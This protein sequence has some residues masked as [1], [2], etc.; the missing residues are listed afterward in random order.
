MK[1]RQP[2]FTPKVG[3]PALYSDEWGA[4]R[5]KVT[6]VSRHPNSRGYYLC[7]ALDVVDPWRTCDGKLCAPARFLS[8]VP[9]KGRKR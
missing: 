5:V 9:S 8:A 6:G 2:A 7:T 1:T 4:F 3:K